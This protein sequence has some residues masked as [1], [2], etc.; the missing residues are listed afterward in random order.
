MT[1]QFGFSSLAIQIPE[2]LLPAKEIDL[3]KWAVVACDQYT[4]QPDYWA[5]VKNNTEGQASSLNVIFPE[6]YL[7]DSDG[8]QRISNINQTMSDYINNG[9]LAPLAKPGFVL[10]DRKTSQVPSRKGLVVSIDLEAYDFTK[11]SS[12]LI[13]ETY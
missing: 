7:E 1:D 3:S 5:K 8:A 2:I 13:V 9:T 10:V 6:V 11:G 12:S 4:S